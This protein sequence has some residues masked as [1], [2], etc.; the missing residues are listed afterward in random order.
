MSSEDSSNP[1]QQAGILQHVLAYV[2]PGH[3]CFVAEVSSLWRE[4]YLKIA[5]RRLQVQV[6]H[7][8]K[9]RTLV[10]TLVPRM[11]M[12]SAVFGSPSRVL[13]AQAHEL[14]STTE[15][16]QSTAGKYADVATLEA[17][18]ELG[19]LYSYAAIEGAAQRN[20][21]AVVQFLHAQGCFLSYEMFEAAAARGHTEMCAYLHSQDCPC[22]AAACENAA[23]NGH[24]NTL[25]WLYEHD[26]PFHPYNLQT[27]AAKGGSVAVLKLLQP[28]RASGFTP[29]S[30]THMLNVA[31]AHNQP[32]AA[33]W[34]RQQGAEWPDALC[35]YDTQQWSEDAEAWARAEGCTSS[36]RVPSDSS[37]DSD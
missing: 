19:I 4:L 7:M 6:V 14:C 17:A 32:A 22:D 9:T 18:H 28:W 21:F 35:L 20:A 13:H 10:R 23:L 15:Q 36:S 26:C 1:L 11:T 27:A 5:K 16:Y 8:E 25:R 37:S 29:H 24:C 2:G 34:L 30:M 33:K 31:G 3:W 12:Y